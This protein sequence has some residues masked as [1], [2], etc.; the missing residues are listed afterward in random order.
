MFGY[1]S[2]IASGW[3]A[4]V[5]VSSFGWDTTFRVL[6]ICSCLSAVLFSICWHAKPREN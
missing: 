2:G 4:G 3:G 6:M 1:A 5:M